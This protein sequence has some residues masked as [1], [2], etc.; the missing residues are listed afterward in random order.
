LRSVKA[1]KVTQILT[2]RVLFYPARR[3]EAVALLPIALR[4]RATVRA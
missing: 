3:L 4:C 2:A 1:A